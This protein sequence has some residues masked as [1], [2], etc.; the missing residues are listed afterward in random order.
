ML[1]HLSVENFALLEKM[2]VEL[3]PGLNVITGETGAGKSLFVDAV[4]VALGA[5]GSSEYI[6]SG[7]DTTHVSALF[8]CSESAGGQKLQRLSFASG[9]DSEVL[10]ERQLRR[11][12]Q[13]RAW[14][15]GRLSSVN[16][17]K[18]FAR[19]MVDMHGQHQQQ[20]LLRPSEQLRMLDEMA[21]K[22]AQCAAATVATLHHQLSG[23]RDEL[24]DLTG[25]DKERARRLDLLK[26]Q[27]RE[28]DEAELDPE[29]EQDLKNRQ[30]IL[31]N[32]QQLRSGI[33][34]LLTRLNDGFQGASPVVD[35]VGQMAE[36][37]GR[38]ADIDNSLREDADSLRG[39]Q[40][41]LQEAG[42]TLRHYLENLDYDPGQ[43]EQVQ[44][45][46]D[47][48]SQLKSKYGNSVQEVLQY[49]EEVAG[50]IE[51]IEGSEKRI[52]DLKK[53]QEEVSRQ[54]G[55]AANQ[56]SQLRQKFASTLQTRMQ[57][58]L[59]DL[60]M[61]DAEFTIE[62]QRQPDENGVPVG[63]QRYHCTPFG[64]DT[65]EFMIAPNPG[66]PMMKLRNIASGGELARLMLAL[67]N[68]AA[69]AGSTPVLIFDEI[70]AGV[71][72]KAG[73]AIAQKLDSIA[74]NHQVLSVT[75]LPQVAAAAD[76][77][78]LL[79]K[80]SVAGRT[81]SKLTPV[82]DEVRV[83]EIARMLGGSPEDA[84]AKRH[85]RQLLQMT[86]DGG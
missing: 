59:S 28:I 66:E 5:R 73:R 69:G 68:V 58:E 80:E 37:L 35:E 53:R 79:H 63:Q 82:S 25:D 81:V 67:K 36:S 27:L 9:E 11:D 20:G 65:V 41:E 71:G 14:V 84:A 78:F 40:Y 42:R 21:G 39:V 22:Q 48:I 51:S 30:N 50:H 70:D 15:N 60:H 86:T 26:Y 12:Q 43:L 38:L 49:R 32:L 1:A 83:R 64:I 24:R 8:Y 17:I 61:E 76:A 34:Q 33:G 77:H 7:A 44:R 31:A 4:A 16:S 56:L 13:N 55:E 6:R 45:R 23:I 72:G 62:F 18:E 2:E 3:R 46:L 75:H 57:Q 85:A 19:M 10:I 52:E 47:E 74:K 29:E 54:L